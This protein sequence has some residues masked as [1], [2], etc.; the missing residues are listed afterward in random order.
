M[1]GDIEAG[2]DK[3]ITP[4]LAFL[5]KE[6]KIYGSC[7]LGEQPT[8]AL[9]ATSTAHTARRSKRCLIAAMLTAIYLAIVL[10]PL[11]SLAM[12][13]NVVVHA[14]TGECSGD[15]DLCGCSPESRANRTCCCAKK[16]QQLA[17]V[18]V[19]D[20]EG[21]PD[22]CKKEAAAKKTIISCGC[23]CGSRTK[24]VLSTSASSEVLP[25]HF[26]EQFNRPHAI[27]TCS[28]PARRLASR[29]REP[30]DPPPKL[31]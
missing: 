30:P 31:L 22:C 14:I 20:E 19:D 10:S 11:V 26:M 1:A 2:R 4:L 29:H 23:P 17:H 28:S 24:A 21:T 9:L 8:G 7:L 5:E 3:P 27:S 13:S 15:C 6:C 12:Q 18:H 25:F 16:R